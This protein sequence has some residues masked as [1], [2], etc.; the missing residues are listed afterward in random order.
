MAILKQR[1]LREGSSGTFDTIHLETESGLVIMPD[2]SNLDQIVEALQTAISNKA[3]AS[4][5][6]TPSSIGAATTSHT[7]SQYLTSHQSLA[8]YVPTSRTIAGKSLSANISAD[9]LKTALGIDGGSGGVVI[10]SPSS[11]ICVNGHYIITSQLDETIASTEIICTAR[12]YNGAWK[13][14][15]PKGI[16][17]TIYNTSI[18]WYISIGVL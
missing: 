8:G 14:L 1:L 2:G 13:Y 11:S 16:A 10:G 18:K 9:A 5:T 3:A 17:G 7:H 6:H 12:Y 15:T 4:H